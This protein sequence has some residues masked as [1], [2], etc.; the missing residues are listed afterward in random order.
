MRQRAAQE[1]RRARQRAPAS[2]RR[3]RGRQM[4][5]C[6]VACDRSD[7][8]SDVRDGHRPDPRVLD[9]VAQQVGQLLLDLVADARRTLRGSFKVSYNVLETSTISY[10]SSW[11]PFSTSLKFF[12]DR[13]HSNPAFTS[14]ARR[15]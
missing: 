5:K 11:S 14:R 4:R 6:T 3:A 15:P 7:V 13:P 12:T 8:T 9:L 10:T 1:A 2:S